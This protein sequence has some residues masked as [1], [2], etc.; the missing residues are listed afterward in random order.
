MKISSL[1]G[2]AASGLVLFLACSKATV[3][4]DSSVG[5]QA[6]A[7][8]TEEAMQYI[9]DH[10][11]P[12]DLAGLRAAPE[13]FRRIVYSASSPETKARVWREHLE[14]FR[15]AD[16]ALTDAQRSELAAVVEVLTP[17]FFAEPGYAGLDLVALQSSFGDLTG[18]VFGS[19]E[20]DSSTRADPQCE[21]S[22]AP[23]ND[24]C[25]GDLVCKD[26]AYN[27]CKPTTD[28]CGWF[29]KLPCT[30]LCK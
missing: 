30:G 21:C 9:Q 24:F 3:A 5:A 28:G 19:L 6:S 23:L 16:S 13:S 20:L 26:L 14:P 12:D 4:P 22:H 7:C 27:G 2:V 25:P 18:P 1:A 10:G 15:A 29:F 8:S 17:E 11:T